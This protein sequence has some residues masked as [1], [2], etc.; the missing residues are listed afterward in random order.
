MPLSIDNLVQP[1][2]T[3]SFNG[4]SGAA[5]LDTATTAGSTVLIVAAYGA[6]GTSSY[7]LSVPAGFVQI[8][9]L[10]GVVTGRK[11]VPAVFVKRNVSA[12]E[13]SWTLTMA[14]TAGQVVWAAYELVGIGLDLLNAWYVNVPLFATPYDGATPA[15]ISTTGTGTSSCFDVLAF[16]V[17]AARSATTTPVTWSGHTNG[18]TE[19]SEVSRDDGTNALSM[20]V[21]YLPSLALG[22]F[23]CTADLSAGAPATATCFVLYAD[24]AKHAPDLALIF[25]AELG[26][27]TNITNGS[28]AQSSAAVDGMAGAPEILSSPSPRS[29]NYFWR[30]SSSAA[31]ENFTWTAAGTLGQCDPTTGYPLLAPFHFRFPTSLPTTDVPIAS[32]EAGSL[33][34]GVVFWYRTATQ[35]IGV[36]IGTGTEQVSD[37][38]VTAGHWIGIDPRY[39]PRAT[40]H[41]LDWYLDYDS[42]PGDSTGWVAQA[43]ASTTGMTAADITTLRTGWHDARTATVDYDDLAV[44]KMWG[45]FPLGTLG[46]YPVTVDPVGTPTIERLGGTGDAGNFRTFSGGGSSL[47]AWDPTVARG[48]VAEIPP[49]LGGTGIAQITFTTSQLDYAKIPMSTRTAAPS[50]VLRA[51]RWYAA[52]G[53]AS[54]TAASFGVYSYDGEQQFALFSTSDHGQDGTTLLWMCKMHRDPSLDGIVKFYQL[55]QARMNGMALGFGYA[56]DAAPDLY[57]YGVLGEVAAAPADVFTYTEAPGGFR[58]YVRQ[59]PNS[60]AIVS[61]LVTTPPG[62]R[63][64]TLYWTKNGVDDFHYTNPDTPDDVAIAAEG[65]YDL[66]YVSLVIDPP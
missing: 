50:E 13:T 41:L 10:P 63:G 62:T 30:C 22:T 46:V 19:L 23:E 2:K 32:I 45:A 40:T 60:A 51:M 44:S 49:A 65:I 17:H 3:G 43:Q 33:A 37:A 12:G 39:D 26:A 66:S 47:A 20:V 36:K 38:V 4:S 35:K 56:Q 31:I 9:G 7:E 57:L 24:A 27:M 48:A 14:G 16:A 58:V 54:G 53:A 5:T 15:S 55:T 29:G 8:A 52:C 59:D 64:A 25:G 11:A 42:T 61:F 18:F 28:I 34:N 6:N 1:P 21:S